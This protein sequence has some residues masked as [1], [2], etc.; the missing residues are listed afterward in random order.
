MELLRRWIVRLVLDSSVLWYGIS[1]IFT[2]LVK[3]SNS[4]LSFCL[5]FFLSSCYAY[6]LYKNWYSSEPKK[7]NKKQKR[8]YQQ[9]TVHWLYFGKSD[10]KWVREAEAKKWMGIVGKS[11][12]WF[13]TKI[14]TVFAYVIEIHIKKTRIWFIKNR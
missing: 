1:T 6:H 2:E 11:F 4:L 8:N 10:E 5:S 3:F 13:S 7:K 12:Y 14:C 9:P